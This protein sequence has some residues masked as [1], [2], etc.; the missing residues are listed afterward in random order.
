[1]GVV[2]ACE[3]AFR[4]L[5]RGALLTDC[6]YFELTALTVADFNRDAGIITV[7]TSKAG[8]PRHVVLTDEGQRLLAHADRWQACQ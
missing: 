5:V 1:V 4:I 8:K 2:D 3:H 7:R 6:R